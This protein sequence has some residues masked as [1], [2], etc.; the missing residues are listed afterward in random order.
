LNSCC[1]GATLLIAKLDRLA[2]NVAF[3]ANLLEAGVEATAVDMPGANK[4]MLHIVATVAEQE[5]RAISDRT[6]AA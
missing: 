1:G 2:R 5:V 3:I 4:F 6:K